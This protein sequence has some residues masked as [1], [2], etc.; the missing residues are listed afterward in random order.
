MLWK[1]ETIQIHPEKQFENLLTPEEMKCLRK[2]KMPA[3]SQLI[4]GGKG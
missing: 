2:L 3:Y 4:K 1:S